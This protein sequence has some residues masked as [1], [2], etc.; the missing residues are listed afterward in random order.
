VNGAATRPGARRVA[1]ICAGLVALTAAVFAP[2]RSHEFVSWDDAAYVYQNPHVAAG[3]TRDGVRWAFTTFEQGNWHPLTWLSH[4]LDVQLFGMDAG[5]HHVVGVALHALNALLLFDVLRRMTGAPGRSAFVAA[6]F[7]VHPMHVESVAWAAERKDLLSALFLMLSLEAYVAYVRRPGTGRYLALCACFAAG[8]A[9]KPMIVTLP[10]VLLLLDHWPLARTAASPRPWGPLVREKLPLFALAAASC[11]VT[12]AA[13]RSARAVAPADLFPL[14]DR[15]ANAS[16]SYVAYAAKTLWP[17]RLAVLYPYPAAFPGWQTA[18]T[19]LL[20]AVVTVAAVRG[21]RRRPY[22]A[23]GWLWFVGTLVPVIGIVQVGSQAMADRYSYVPMIGLLVAVAWGVPELVAA[24][25]RWNAALPVAAA[26]AIAACAVAARRQVETWN[27]SGTLW[28]QALECTS[29]NVIAQINRGAWLVD[30][31]RTDEALPLLADA[32]RVAPGHPEAQ[33][34]LGHALRRQGKLDEAIVHFREALRLKPEFAAAYDNLGLALLQ[35]GKLDE[36]IAN[37]SEALRLAP[38]LADA[39]RNMSA[40]LADA[41]RPEAAID[42]AVAAV[43]LEPDN[44]DGHYGLGDLLARTG[45]AGDA[46]REFETALRLD[47]N[48]ADARRALD[49]L[50]RTTNRLDGR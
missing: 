35:Q 34:N 8:L 22:A 4:M 41:G 14:G 25:P 27:D 50:Q 23:V 11:A 46:V 20:L 16:M 44:A 33:N 18:A 49:E 36:A 13:Q 45:R 2:V 43:R 37:L 28:E 38:G 42:E 9:A 3:L 48:H 47:P 5:A 30:H 10:F 12:I 24:R 31:G 26:L 32:V 1:W 7:A 17:A 19:A 29:G 6:V 15:L 39:H 40:A 21:A